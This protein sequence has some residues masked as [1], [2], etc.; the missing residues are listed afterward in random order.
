[1]DLRKDV[2]FYPT[3]AS[4]PT[5]GSLNALYVDRASGIIYSWNGSS[6]VASG[7]GPVPVGLNYQGLWNAN[8]NSPLITSGDGVVGD[9]YIV[10]T[11]GTTS[12]D[13]INDWGIG[14]WIIFSSTGVWQK[15]DNSDKEGYNTI[16]DEGSVLPQR[17]TINFVGAGV[18]AA[19]SGGKTVVTINGT[20]ISQTDVIYVDSVNGADNGDTSRGNIDKPYATIDYVIANVINTGTVTG[21][22]T[23]ANATITNVSSTANI[24]V[25]QYIAGTNIPYGSIVLSKTVNT[26]VLSKNATGTGSAITFTWYTPKLVIANG[27]FTVSSNIFKDGFSFDFKNSSVSFS[28]ILLNITAKFNVPFEL[29]STGD[30]TGTGTG[31]QLLVNAANQDDLS[32]F[33][34]NINRYYSRGTGIAIDINGY[35]FNIDCTATTFNAAFGSVCRIG[36]IGPSPSGRQIFKGYF[37]GFLGGFTSVSKTSG[38]FGIEGFVECPSTVTA[39]SANLNRGYLIGSVI[40]KCQFINFAVNG[41]ITGDVVCK[42]TNINGTISTVAN[43]T[44]IYNKSNIGWL[45]ANGSV[46]FHG[47]AFDNGITV[48]M[49]TGSGTITSSTQANVTIDMIQGVTLNWSTGNLTILNGGGY[50]ANSSVINASGGE[51]NI[52]GRHYFYNSPGLRTTSNGIVNIFG[53]ILESSKITCAGGRM[54]NYGRLKSGVSVSSGH[55]YNSGHIISDGTIAQTGGTV[56]LDGGTLEMNTTGATAYLISKTSG[57]L[58]LRGQNRFK[59]LNGKGPL[60]CTANTSASKDIYNFSSITNCDGT[61]YGLLIAWDGTA[62]AANDLVGGTL[63][64]NTAY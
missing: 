21:D 53:G 58:L 22:T 33:Q 47:D 45:V 59:V 57:T 62:F 54:N 2:Y 19:D 12:I 35:S 17:S 52:Y 50:Y 20:S 60:K 41:N 31:S 4:F 29:N 28:T 24:K 10:G 43:S 40:G 9:Y 63:Y 25:G 13:G 3:L 26:I 36:F 64:E 27:N 16:E 49:L 48:K 38:L 30:I 61:T 44:Y 15:I 14:D 37:Y 46:T 42:N 56:E 55:F 34:L 11:A 23:N 7:P 18:S 51:V 6:Y 32:D 39:I 5:S 8:S 1:M